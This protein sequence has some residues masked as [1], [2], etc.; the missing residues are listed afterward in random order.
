MIT[1]A[2]TPSERREEGA[3]QTSVIFFVMFIFCLSK[4]VFADKSLPVS[5]STQHPTV[6][7]NGYMRRIQDQKLH[8]L[9]V[10][11]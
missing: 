4:V 5:V 2:Q 8:S 6:Y 3:S 10:V 11:F 7:H 9:T 1:V